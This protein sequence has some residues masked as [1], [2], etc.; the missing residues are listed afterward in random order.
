MFKAFFHTIAAILAL[1]GASTLSANA[2][3]KDTGDTAIPRYEARLGRERAVIAVVGF[4]AA[5]EVTDYVVPYGVLAESGVA[6][7]VALGTS[8][9][10][11]QMK[12]ALRFN[13]QAT[14]HAFDMRYPDGADYVVVPNVYEGENDPALLEWLRSQAAKGATIV[15][16]CDGVP[17]LANAG[18]LGGP[19][20]NDALA[21]DRSAGAQASGHAMG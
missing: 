6:D 15:G 9:G 8:D 13:P 4:N 10:P 19:A 12:P 18:L 20:R 2:Q 7:V 5:T 16:I 17:T 14:I 21:H 11:I 1:T 3:R